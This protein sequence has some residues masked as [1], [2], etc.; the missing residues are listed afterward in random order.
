M[1]QKAFFIIFEGLSNAKNNLRPE[2]A[3]LKSVIFESELLI[4]CNNSDRKLSFT[5]P[6]IDNVW[7]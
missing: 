2:S 1:K 4:S 3:P 7:F 6:V 5:K